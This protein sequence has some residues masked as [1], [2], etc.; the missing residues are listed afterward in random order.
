MALT[1]YGYPGMNIEQGHAHEGAALKKRQQKKHLL[2]E[3]LYQSLDAMALLMEI[4]FESFEV[5]HCFWL[6]L[7]CEIDK[8]S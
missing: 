5:L 6:P 7:Y 1:A 8:I 3:V 2:S 4:G